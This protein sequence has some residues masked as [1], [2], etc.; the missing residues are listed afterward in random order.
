[1]SPRSGGQIRLIRDSRDPYEYTHLQK[2][3]A[4]IVGVL[5]VSGRED[6]RHGAVLCPLSGVIPPWGEHLSAGEEAEVLAAI[7]YAEA[8]LPGL[9]SHLRGV[10][11]V[12]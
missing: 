6:L 1:M 5:H 9:V 10:R 8:T 2:N 3:N 12:Y 7:A 4:A 11:S